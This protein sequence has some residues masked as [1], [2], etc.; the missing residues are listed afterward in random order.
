MAHTRTP[1]AHGRSPAW[2]RARRCLATLLLAGLSVA[3]ARAQPTLLSADEA[4]L[5]AALEHQARGHPAQAE[6]VLRQLAER[7][8]ATAMER[9]ALLHWYGHTLYPGTQWSRDTARLWFARAAERGSEL[10]RHMSSVIARPR[11]AAQRRMP[12]TSAA[13]ADH[14]GSRFTYDSC[15]CTE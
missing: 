12:P 1:E 3:S 10:G 14:D 4:A 11:T 2:R 9:L 13:E 5:D 6:A 15:G 8:H 7:G